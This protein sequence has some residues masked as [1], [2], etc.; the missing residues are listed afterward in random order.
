MFVLPW[1]AAHDKSISVLAMQI[2]GSI[3]TVVGLAFHRLLTSGTGLQSGVD[4]SRLSR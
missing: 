1:L 2:M 3:I 4:G